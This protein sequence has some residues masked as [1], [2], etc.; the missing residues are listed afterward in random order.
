LEGKKP[1]EKHNKH[2]HARRQIDFSKY[3]MVKLAFRFSYIGEKFS[4]LVV[5]QN[6]S[7]TIEQHILNA[8]KKVCLI[9]PNEQSSYASCLNRCGRTDKGVSALNNVLSIILRKLPDGDYLTRINRELPPDIRM[10]GWTEV[11]NSFDA[12]FSCVFRE[13]NYFF[14]Q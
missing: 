7:N 13:Y 12:R 2:N 10:L 4:G 6:D 11:D 5:Q 14:F 9:N 1:N 8:L 3:E